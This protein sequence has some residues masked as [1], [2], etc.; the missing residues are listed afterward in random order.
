MSRT[1]GE[2]KVLREVFE[3]TRFVHDADAS[4]SVVEWSYQ[5]AECAGVAVWVRGRETCALSSDWR[6]VIVG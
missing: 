3:T 6:K 1:L 2:Q 4:M 5:N